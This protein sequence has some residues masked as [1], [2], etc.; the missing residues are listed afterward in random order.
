MN[1]R[2]LMIYIKHYRQNSCLDRKSVRIMKSLKSYKVIKIRKDSI[3]SL[4]YRKS[5][6]SQKIRKI[7]FVII[8]MENR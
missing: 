7:N 8:I 6:Y 4:L 3:L 5:F 1:F 2:D